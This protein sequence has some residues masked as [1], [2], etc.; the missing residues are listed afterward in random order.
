MSRKKRMQNLREAKDRRTKKIAVGGAVLFV[1]VLAFEVPH[2][3]GGGSKASA[4]ASTTATTTGD[5]AASSTATPA[6]TPTTT[7]QGTAVAAALP[8]TASTKLPNSDLAPKRAKSQ[9][10][11]FT[12]FSGKDPFVQQI[13][14]GTQLPTPTSSGTSTPPPTVQ[15]TASV[16]SR[17]AQQGSSKPSARTLAKTGAATISVNGRRETV[18]IGAGFPSSNPLFRLISVSHGVA[19][20]GVANGSYASGAQTVSL[21]TGRTLTLVDTADGIHYKLRL[22]AAA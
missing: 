2:M 10:Y 13:S 21:V 3:L 5:A 6:G 17:S 22:L 12:H 15:Q 8:T 4:P 9:L 20:I 14:S 19:R 7:P 16:R 1:A 18:R 11:S